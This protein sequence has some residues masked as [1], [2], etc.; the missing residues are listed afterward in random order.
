MLK[1]TPVVLVLL[2]AASAFSST[3]TAGS[4]GVELDLRLDTADM[5]LRN[6]GAVSFRSCT[7]YRQPIRPRHRRPRSAASPSIRLNPAAPD[8]CFR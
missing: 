1:S 4:I 3:I 7:E 6:L 5:A 2:S 8:R